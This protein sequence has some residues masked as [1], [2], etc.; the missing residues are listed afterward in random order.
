[1]AVVDAAS[2]TIYD[3]TKKNAIAR[4]PMPLATDSIAWH[5]RG[6]HLAV[7]DGHGQIAIWDIRRDE[8]VRTCNGRTSGIRIAFSPDGTMIA[9]RAWDGLWRLHDAGSGSQKLVEALIG[10][11]PFGR[12]DRIVAGPLGSEM[13]LAEIATGRE[14]LTLLNAGR[15]GEI[16]SSIA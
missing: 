8:I 4:H 3:P 9:S 11:Q 13:G 5:P 12:E 16:T 1:L 14:C 6:K 7:A 10:G 15:R 2:V